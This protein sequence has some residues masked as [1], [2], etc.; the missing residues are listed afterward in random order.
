[1]RI[2]VAGSS[3][4]IERAVSVIAGL[5]AAGHEITHDWTVE[6]TAARLAGYSDATYPPE[7]RRATAM[8]DY[9]GVANAE[10][11][12][13]LIPPADKPSRG[14]WVELGIALGHEPAPLII[15]VGDGGQS[16]F[17]ELADVCLSFDEDV[18]GL[19]EGAVYV[20]RV[21]VR[22]VL[23]AAEHAHIGAGG[24]DE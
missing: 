11:A 22:G 13:F 24:G 3:R 5:R 23:T 21:L 19:L 17:C 6:C 12:V 20:N 2:Y 16:I 1:M 7:M 4:E 9:C 14:M 8:A 10:V 18:V 15:V